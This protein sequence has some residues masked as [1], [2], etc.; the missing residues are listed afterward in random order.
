MLGNKRNAAADWLAVK[1]RLAADDPL[2]QQAKTYL[3][4]LG[5]SGALPAPKD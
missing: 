2:A 5:Q 4:A 1:A 3:D